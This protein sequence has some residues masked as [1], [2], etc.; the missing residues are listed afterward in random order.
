MHIKNILQRQRKAFEGFVWP[1]HVFHCRTWL[2]FSW[3]HYYDF[4]HTYQ[5]LG[6]FNKSDISGELSAIQQSLYLSKTS[7]M[8]DFDNRGMFDK[9]FVF[10]VFLVILIICW[11]FREPHLLHCV[12]PSTKCCIFWPVAVKRYKSQYHARLDSPWQI[13]VTRKQASY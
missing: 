12:W 1:L 5:V 10:H 2:N 11:K 9:S 3:E 13:D 6:I 7:E 4:L 8:A